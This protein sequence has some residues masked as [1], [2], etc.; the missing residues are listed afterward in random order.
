MRGRRPREAHRA[1]TPLE[2]FFDLCFV[3]AIAQAGSRLEHAIGTTH[4]QSGIV[5]FLLI[6]FA[7]WWAWMNFTWFASAYDTDDVPYRVATLVQIS[8]VLI[9]ASGVPHA[10]TELDFT[11]PILGYAVMRT[12]LISQWL[13]AAVQET[14]SG[15]R[16][17]CL[18]Y[19]LG[20]AVAE[21]CWISWLF[22]P[23]GWRLGCFVMFACVELAVPLF[24]EW[25]H[26]TPWHPGH[27]GERYG[28][29]TIIVLGESV[30]AAT[31]GIQSVV[32]WQGGGGLGDLTG[33][34]I[35]G[36][37]IVFAM[38]WQYFS[39]PAHELVTRRS[40]RLSHSLLWGYGHLFLFAAVA[41]VGPGLVVA[42]H[43]VLGEN[44]LGPRAAGAAVTIPVALYVLSVEFLQ[45]RSYQR[46]GLLRW[47]FPA[48]AVAVL[49]ATFAPDPVVVT[50]VL[51]SVSVAAAVAVTGLT[52]V[53]GQLEGAEAREPEALVE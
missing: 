47:I 45:L 30:T 40:R 34:V 39:V 42:A 24:A 50:G 21:V 32:D 36:L 48:C 46:P 19:A 22:V 43:Q 51:L 20:I 5:G 33:V 29:F 8:G 13:R 18:R 41:A 53:P 23:E 9:L 7:I 16:R 37:L 25:Y 28:L 11:V 38:W 6:F 12:A 26:R 44:E 2:L 35:G 27:I 17:T 10:L 4:F 15:R 3:V 14:T 49:A 52:P 1:A 31:L